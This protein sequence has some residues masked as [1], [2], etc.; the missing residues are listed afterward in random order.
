MRT[1]WVTGWPRMRCSTRFAEVAKALAQRPTGRDR[2]RARPGRALGRRD[3][4]RDRPERRQHL[5]SPAGHGPRRA[6]RHP[7]RRH[8]DLLPAGQRPGRP[9]CGRRCATSPPSTSPAS[10][11]SPPPTSATATASRSIEP[12]RAGAPGC[13]RGDVRRARR[14]A[15]RPSSAPATSP[16]R[17]RCRSASC[18]ASCAPCPRT[19]RSSPTA[20]ARTA[21]TPTT[22]CASCSRQGLPGP[23]TRGRVPGVE[24]SRSAGGGRRGG[25]TM[26]DDLLVDADTLRAQVRDKYREVAV[27]PAP[28]L[29]LPHRPA[30]GGP[31]R[32]RRRRWSTRCPIGPSSPSP[33]SAT[34]SRCGALRAG[35]AR[36]RRRLRRRVR[37]VR[38]R[39][40]GRRRRAASSAST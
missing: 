31:A 23:P 17:G 13:A 8:T 39:R 27:D 9:S 20:A 35:R 22:P 16:G 4:G 1:S 32:L 24:A 19:S 34:R 38:R 6:G 15:R 3:R 7:P 40:P 30:A 25:L 36:R 14:P 5:A 11:G 26:A 12:R 10:N 37:L 33:A 2:R 29:P 21:C 28:Q 18:A